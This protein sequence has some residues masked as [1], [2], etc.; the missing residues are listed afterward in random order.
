MKNIMPSGRKV[1]LNQ[2]GGA[3]KSLQGVLR[4]GWDLKEHSCLESLTF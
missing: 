1:G 4:R 2:F 3:F